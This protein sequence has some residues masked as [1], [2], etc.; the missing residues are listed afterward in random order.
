MAGKGDMEDP[1][2]TSDKTMIIFCSE[3]DL[4]ISNKLLVKSK[5]ALPL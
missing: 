4:H 1:K 3:E 2:L 5:K